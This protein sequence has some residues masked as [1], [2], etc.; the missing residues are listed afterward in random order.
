MSY[1]QKYQKYQTKYFNLLAGAGDK[2]GPVECHLLPTEPIPPEQ[3]RTVSLP[4]PNNH[5]PLTVG[6][7]TDPTGGNKWYLLG[8]DY[9]AYNPIANSYPMVKDERGNDVEEK[10]GSSVYLVRNRNN[11]TFTFSE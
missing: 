1:Y 8:N 3:R 10:H 4:P 6:F 7:I 2:Q 9:L 11:N 5:I